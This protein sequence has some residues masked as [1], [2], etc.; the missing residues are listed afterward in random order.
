[1]RFE[2]FEDYPENL[3]RVINQ[4]LDIIATRSRYEITD[5]FPFREQCVKS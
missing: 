5:M 2:R 1:M 3:E 4:N